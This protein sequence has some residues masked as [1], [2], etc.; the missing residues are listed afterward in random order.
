VLL[1]VLLLVWS[2][3]FLFAKIALREFPA[4]LVACLR[5]VVAGAFM[6]PIYFWGRERWEER[7]EAWRWRDW[8]ALLG[9][10]IFGLVGN[11]VVFVYAISRTSV[12]HSA[13]IVTLGPLLVLAGA[14]WLGQERLTRAKL[15]G[16]LVAACGVL[17]LQFGHASKAGSSM[18]GDLLMLV[19]ITM[20]AAFTVL[21]KGLAAR[22]GPI[23]INTFAFVGGAV[24]LLPYTIWELSRYGLTHFGLQAWLSV[25]YMGFFP[26]IIGYLI[27]SYALRHLPASQ[28]SSVSYLQTVVATLLGVVFLGERPGACFAVGAV[29]VLGGV[30]LARRPGALKT[31]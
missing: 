27:Y 31:P 17:A 3:N 24:L 19:S 29:L 13:L 23:T 8:P 12:A 20:F 18:G 5:T 1:G 10:G 4:S 28:V 14:V 16:M 6:A 15:V 21:G 30:W 26:S 11:Q 2:G 22:F 7:G 9:I 25:F